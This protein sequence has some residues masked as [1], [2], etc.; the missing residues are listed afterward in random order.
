VDTNNDGTIDHSYNGYGNTLSDWE[1]LVG[2]NDAAVVN[3][4]PEL[5]NGQG[6]DAYVVTWYDQSVNG[7][8]ATQ[9]TAGSQPKIAEAGVLLGEI[10][11]DGN[12]DFLINENAIWDTISNTNL[13]CMTVTEK[14]YVT[15]RVLWAI[16]D[17]GGED[18]DWLIGGGGT[19]GQVQFRGGRINSGAVSVGTSGA[20]LL[21]ALDVTGGDGYVD[22]VASGAPTSVSP[23]RTADRLVLFTRRGSN[24]LG[25]CTDQ[26][27]K[28][29][30]FFNS[31]QSD[32]RFKIESNIN[33]HYGIYTPAHNGFVETWYDQSGNGN[34][35][36]QASTGDQPKIVSAGSYLG[37]L[38]FD[39]VDDFLSAGT[40]FASA[41]KT[42][43]CVNNPN[44]LN[45]NGLFG[46]GSSQSDRFFAQY[47]L[48]AIRTEINGANASIAATTQR[49]LTTHLH[50]DDISVGLNGSSLTT[51]DASFG[52]VSSSAELR[53]GQRFGT[54][55]VDNFDGSIGEFVFYNSDQ[56]ANRSDIEDNINSHYSIYP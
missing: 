13:S 31:D 36:E 45:S 9:D 23:N 46:F 41:S 40:G 38:E 27:I 17:S 49:N 11:P 24:S 54:A 4:S 55:F 28:E 37:E 26:A 50:T 2:S 22:G 53:I 14:T 35:A 47:N 5:F 32:N 42:V 48:N 56:S 8:D 29:I 44:L 30:I 52:G 34:H 51:T 12:D 19:A 10:K 33:N 16:G 3:G 7:Y 18:G 21:T 1:D 39:G 15:N 6:F 43:F 25:T 20:V